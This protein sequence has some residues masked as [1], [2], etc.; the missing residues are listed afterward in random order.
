MT[1]LKN[2]APL[3]F[4]TEIAETQKKEIR[5][6]SKKL[7]LTGTLRLLVFIAGATTLYLVLGN[8]LYLSIT[9][10]FT[11]AIFFLLLKRH[12]R[13]NNQKQYAAA[14]LQIAENEI[15]GFHNDYSAFDGA[16]ER[17]QPKHNF[18]FDLDIFGTK[19]VFQLFNRTVLAIGKERLC[20]FVEHPL[21]EVSKIK[22]RQTAIDE[23]SRKTNFCL[24]FRATG[25]LSKKGFSSMEEVKKTFD[26]QPFF[27]RTR[28][29]Q[30]LT[31][32]IP[33]IYAIYFILLIM[34]V[35]SAKYLL[36]L[37]LLTLGVST[38]PMKNIKRVKQTFDDKRNM[39]NTYSN[40]LYMI[41]NEHFESELL[42]NIQSVLKKR[43]SA[44]TLI[45]HLSIYH[46]NLELS[47]TF[48]MLLIFNPFF[49][50]NV[51][52]A[53]KIERWQKKYSNSCS[54]WLDV[55]GKTDALVSLATFAFNNPDYIFPEVLST[56]ACLEAKEMGHPLISR[57][58]CI[59]N[60]INISQSPYFMIITGANMAGKSTYLR[61]IGINLVLACMGSVVC[62]KQ[63][64]FYPA[65]LLT[66]LRTAD[67]LVNNESYFLAELKRLKMII[68][69]LENKQEPL[70]IILD[71]ILKGTNSED[72]QNG[73]LALIKRFINMGGVGIIATHDL[74]LGS[75]EQQFPN[76]VKN[77]HFDASISN[78][79]LVFTYKLNDGIATKMNATFLMK[80]MNIID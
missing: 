41:E 68:S 21:N 40:M 12:E 58:I 14:L 62:A 53:L 72:K 16:P 54:D 9:L 18:S 24:S 27:H 77:Y 17:I 50:W 15:K 4:Y 42:S 55:L 3:S 51:K 39:L 63:F 33:I 75:L 8:V 69:Q 2:R 44:S 20:D 59:R 10:L 73:S 36:P 52:Y 7:Y 48:P 67:S 78:D 61:T 1:P 64:R 25:T 28:W 79:K 34:S 5:L 49:L 37:Y 46:R 56:P 60:D 43:G 65:K 76:K 26:F 32:A 22:Q 31:I 23:L 29:W 38:I 35:I 11:A 66:N 57:E 47:F 71:E 30:T 45:K 70:F 13:L 19:S 6:L 74:A 80:A